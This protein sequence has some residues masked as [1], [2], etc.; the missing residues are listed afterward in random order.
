MQTAEGG[1]FNKLRATMTQ[2]RTCGG[3]R[4]VSIVSLQPRR[5]AS[6]TC[7]GIV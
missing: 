2:R 1:G 4:L 6:S 5:L 3:L 7:A